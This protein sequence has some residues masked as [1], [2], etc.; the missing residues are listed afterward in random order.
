MDDTDK[1]KA[2]LRSDECILHLPRED[3]AYPGLD[4]DSWRSDAMKRAVGRGKLHHASVPTRTERR[5]P[6]IVHFHHAHGD[7][8]L[9][10]RDTTHVK[11][12]KSPTASKHGSSAAA[13]CLAAAVVKSLGGRPGL[14]RWIGSTVDINKDNKALAWKDRNLN[15]HVVFVVRHIQSNADG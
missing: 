2:W 9:P 11:G 3:P 5:C 6:R 12:A 13:L 8:L 15:Q 7:P 4:A 14:H 10:K 1:V